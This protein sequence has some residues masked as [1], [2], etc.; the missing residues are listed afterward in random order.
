MAPNPNAS[1]DIEKRRQEEHEW[2]SEVR[3]SDMTWREK[4]REEDVAWRELTRRDEVEMRERF[5]AEDTRLAT[6]RCALEASCQ[7]SAPGTPV[8]ELLG[9]AERYAAWL[10]ADGERMDAKHVAA[11]KQA[12]MRKAN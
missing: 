11:D 1:A 2:R 4:N 12:V 6:R 9:L 10:V 7:S 5:H 8:E 3:H